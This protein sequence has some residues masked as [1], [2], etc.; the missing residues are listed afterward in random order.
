M[1][2][3]ALAIKSR[4]S[5]EERPVLPSSGIS[6]PSLRPI[7]AGTPRFILSNPRPRSSLALGVSQPTNF[8][9]AQSSEIEPQSATQHVQKLR[10]LDMVVSVPAISQQP[11]GFQKL[12]EYEGEVTCVTEL[13]FVARLTDLTDVK[14]QRLEATFSLN[15]V[16]P[17]D[18]SLLRMGAIFYWVIGFRDHPNG[19]RV[20]ENF[21]RFRRLPIWSKRDIERVNARAAELKAFLQSVD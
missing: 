20:T 13:E 12:Q 1:P 3:T 19:Q 4:Q 5:Q 17:S 11:T 21:I 14:G 8:N 18:T 7:I 6:S 16:S 9:E 15:E 2:R 10:P